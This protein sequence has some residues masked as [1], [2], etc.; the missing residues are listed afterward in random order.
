MEYHYE[1]S[2]TSGLL[3]EVSINMPVK[4]DDSHLTSSETKSERFLNENAIFSAMPIIPKYGSSMLSR[5]NLWM[6]ISSVASPILWK[7]HSSEYYTFKNAS[8]TAE[9]SP[10][11]KENGLPQKGRK[12]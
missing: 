9:P 11:Y 2:A 8:V 5:K 3:S 1:D 12:R 10:M 6:G 7:N 4:P